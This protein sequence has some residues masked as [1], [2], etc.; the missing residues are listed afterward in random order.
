MLLPRPEA[1]TVS[2]PERRG[3]SSRR[4]E[5]VLWQ[6]WTTGRVVRESSERGR[7]KE[8]V[9]SYSGSIWSMNFM[10]I[11]G[12]LPQRAMGRGAILSGYVFDGSGLRFGARRSWE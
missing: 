11:E 12:C 3:A 4:A 2:S 6:T 10:A 7:G 1:E 8:E 9:L 5:G